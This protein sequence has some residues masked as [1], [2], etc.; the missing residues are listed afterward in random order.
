MHFKTLTNHN[1][2]SRITLSKA[3][4]EKVNLWMNQINEQ[5]KGM[6]NLK[7]N[8]LVSILLEEFHGKLP[9]QVFDKIKSEKLTD[10][11]KAKWIYLQLKNAESN[12][13]SISFD[14]LLKSTNKNIRLK[15]KKNHK[16]PISNNAKIDIYS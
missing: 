6:I 8:D 4:C 2:Q 16:L 5:F 9:F 3:A 14:S 15:E 11:Q 13:E 10:V 1:L 12:N 7:R